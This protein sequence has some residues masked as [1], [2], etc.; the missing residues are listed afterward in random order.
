MPFFTFNQNNSG[1]EFVL[2]EDAGL[3]HYVIIE[4]PDAEAA[5]AK[6]ESLGGYFD[7]VEEGQ[8]CSCCGDRWW[9]A[10][11]EHGDEAPAI[12]GRPAVEDVSRPYSRQFLTRHWMPPGK[13]LCVHYADGRRVW[14][15]GQV[16]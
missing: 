16:D 2:N 1:G 3:T 14:A 4:A 5:D 8:D 10:W 7:G 15:G 11:P 12:Y 13:E 6:L 9:R